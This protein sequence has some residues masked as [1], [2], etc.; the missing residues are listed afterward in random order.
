MKNNYITKFTLFLAA[1]LCSFL[2]WGQVNITATGNYTQDFNT[3]TNAG[4][5]VPWVDDSTIASWYSQRTGTGTTYAAN[6]G[7]TATGNLY[8][9]GE[10]VVSLERA[11][12][13]IGSGNAAAGS[14]AHGLLLRNTS[15]TTVTNLSVAYTGEQ[16][17]RENVTSQSITFWY[18]ISS[19]PITALTPNNN[20][21]WTAVTV[22]NFISPQNSAAAS[23]LNGNLAVNRVVIPSTAIPSLNLASGDYIMLR[24]L[25]PDHTGN[26]HGLAID[27]VNVSWTVSNDAVDYCNLQ[28]PSAATIIEGGTVSVFAQVYEPGVT[29]ATGQG[30]GILAE[31]GYSTTN[32]DPS[33]AGWTWLPATFNTQVGNNDEFTTALGAGLAPGTYYYASRFQ[34][35]GGP[36]RYGGFPNGFWNGTTQTSGVLTVNPS[37]VDYANVQFPANGTIVSGGNFTVFAQVYEPGVTEAAGQ[38]AGI[39][40]EI[41]YS[42]ANTDPSGGGWTWV[43]ATFNVQSGNNDEYQ[44]EIG[45]TLPA[46]TY[47]YA[48]RFQLGIG[49]FRYG[50][51]NGG[52][53]NGTTNVNGVLTV[54]APEINVQGN[55]TSIVDGDVTP[56]LAD[57]TNFG[58]TT[59]STNITKT[60]TIQNIGTANLTVSNV[61]LTT[62]SV[63]AV[64]GI[65]LPATIT[66]G[67]STTFTITFNSALVGVFNDVVTITNNDSNESSYDFAIRAEATA[68][69]VNCGDLFISEYIEGSSNNKAIEIYNPTAAPINLATYDLVYYSNGSAT[70]TG[71]FALTGTIPAYGTHVV[72]NSSA[73]AAILAVANQT[74]ASLVLTFN[75]DDAIALRKSGVNIDVIGQIGNDPG[76]EWGAGNQSTADNTIIRNFAVQAGDINGADAFN[77]V[78]EWTGFATDYI[79][80]LGTHSNSCA[81]PMPEINV[82]GNSVTIL[83]GDVT[84]IVGDDTNF[85]SADIA[86]G[87]IV[88]TF[89]IQNIGTADLTIGAISFTGTHAANFTLTTP[90]SGTVAAGGSTT[91]QVTFDPTI[92]GTHNAEIVIMNNDSNENPYN[93]AL[94]GT[95]FATPNIVLSSSNPA[96]AASNI[97]Q[98]TINNVIYAF[99]LAVTNADATLNSVVFNTSGI[100]AASNITNFKLWYS[101]D[102]TFN[103]TLDIT[104]DNETAAL[105]IGAHTFTGFTR[106]ITNGSTGY[107]FITTDIPCSSTAGNTIVVDAITTADLTFVLGNKSGTAFA[108]GTHTIQSAIPNNVTGAVTS[109]CENGTATISWTAP[110]GCSDN[111]LVF[112]TNSAFSTA[113]PVGNGGAY[114]D[115]SI[116]GSGTAFDGGF[117]VFKGTGT[118]VTV[119]GLTNGTTYVFKIFTRND[120]NWSNG[121]EVSCTPTLAYCAS[122]ATSSLDSEIENVTLVGFSS[123]ISN[124]TTN[125]CTTGVNNFT[126]LSADLQV[127]GTYTVAVEF[128]DCS[129]G[130]QFD[131]AGGV[132]IDWNND[133]D[134]LDANET[135]GTADIAMTA[136]DTNVIQNFIINVPAG[137]PIGN[138]RMR[139]VQTEAATS[140]AVSPCGTFTYG[141]TED[142]TVQVIN[143]CVPSHTVSS[144]T[145]TSGPVGTEVTI[146]GTNLTGATVTFSGINATIL[147]NDGSTIVAVIPSGAI[148]GLLT[149]SDSQPCA[150]NNSFTIITNDT[151][152]CEGV[153]AVT[154]DLIIYDIHDEQTGSGGF[155][156]LYNGTA[157]TVDLTNY[158]IWRAGDYGVTYTDYAN[159]TG[160]IA[161]GALG[162][163]KV[164]VASC[165]PASTNGTIDGGFNQNDGIQL[166]NATGSVVIDDVQTYVTGPGYYMVRNSGALNART[167]FV[168]ADWNTIPLGPGVC[169]PSAGLILP[170]GSTPPTVTTQPNYS[171]SCGATSVV[172]S[173]AGTEGFAGGNPLAYQWFFAA[174]GNASWTAVSDGG[175]YSGAT[176]AS[177]SI[178]S[179]SGVLNY[180]Y[181]CQIRENTATCYSATN[182]VKITDNNPSIWNGTAWIGG[183]P[184]ITRPVIIDGT[185]VTGTNGNFSCC[186]LTVNAAR[187][188]TIS[189]GGYVEVQNGIT[190]NGNLDVL[191]DGSLVQ[192]ND[193]AVNSGN[194]NY[195]RTTNIRRYDYV[196]WSSPVAG[197]S[198][199]AI[200]PA[201]SLN[202]QLFWTP[203]ISSNTNGFGNWS[204]ANETMVLG[205]GYA[206]RGPNNYSISTLANYTATFTGIPNN[207]L[208]SIPISR[209]TWNGGTY[210][211]GVSTTLG[212]DEDDNWNLV[213]NPYPSAI[214]AIDFLTLNT[215]IAGFVNIWTHGTLPSTAIADPFYNNYDYNYTPGDYITYNASGASSG[216][217][218]FNGSIAGGQ[219]FFV[220]MLHGTAA[221]T[222]NLIFN[223]S[224]RNRVYNNSQFF[225]NSNSVENQTISLERNRIWIDLIASSGS[226]TRAMIGYIENATND[227]DRLFDAFSNEKLAF[228]IFSLIEDEKMLIQGKSLPFNEND[229]VKIGVNIPQDGLYK[230]GIAAVDGLF[231]NTN[232]NIYL[233]DKLLNVIYDLRTAPY[234]FMATKGAIIDRFVIRYTNEAVLSNATFNSNNNIVVVSNEDLSIKS[235]S[236][237]VAKVTIYDVL[238]RKL[239]EKDKVNSS[240]FIVPV[241]KRNTTLLIEITLDN[242][243]KQI[244][245][246]IY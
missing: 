194:I 69:V 91:F 85:G 39:L 225:R 57:D 142:Y 224:L 232:Q 70:V 89:T 61:A 23:S 104:L 30:A 176:T 83:D 140:A 62:G 73:S 231:T 115:N 17:R 185:Y 186:S 126:A 210:S 219:G 13:S 145:P 130:A 243:I 107:F 21:G 3:L 245:K 87:T 27:D 163:L 81:P 22:L 164:S 128:G 197:F 120:L 143:A 56:I 209:G 160:T 213:G 161:P 112:A 154:T 149:V 167:T 67:S 82:Q 182:A 135:I 4:T 218:M 178:S 222:E 63:F 110:L 41:G 155:I 165:G 171:S 114:T 15:G 71:T 162:I 150:V 131:G 168:A 6:T 206:I 44:A 203:T 148:T 117:T 205:K 200:S 238:G 42:T 26:D 212:T 74:T 193:A 99:N 133:G 174:P 72:S 98:G 108:S 141:S 235:Q 208:I 111:V 159:L 109:V 80:D 55:G 7:T 59:V 181:Y 86:G 11:L 204:F 217:G 144:F 127:G 123:T 121:T 20:T 138:Y 8:S 157:S 100:Y 146:N 25:D 40:A 241:S 84:P 60:F 29:E 45:S 116:F 33:G 153:S 192:I 169:Y 177:L 94:I 95:G 172:L 137:Q 92:V 221:T 49:A 2:S 122:G 58:S 228:N 77:P 105:G 242:G 101:T 35:N 198:S 52:F 244:I 183:A 215:N 129:D 43:P 37:V 136:T 229:K 88:K 96:T 124:N 188:L 106:L 216:P 240:N 68:L 189:S 10:G 152:S 147:S 196:Y 156:T 36:F 38:G 190:N 201:T 239:Y 214:N 47:Y 78:T 76:T 93:F 151:S 234:S 19:S 65:T 28:F 48:S 180:Q 227:K 12:G 102:A 34:L 79:A 211:T 54:T 173:T 134:F 32:T 75:G 9:F 132:W 230:I 1:F 118:S 199:A 207:G 97:T 191:S 226:S 64:S 184:T 175:I 170:T 223:N 139:I 18:R 66:A 195:N 236:S 202:L 119:T 16:W 31:I 179:I 14:F 5:A 158:S 51:Y 125:V 187:S 237:K 166:R 24:W 50:G 53:W 46:G 103:S 233:E 246:T 220:S 90:P 113:T